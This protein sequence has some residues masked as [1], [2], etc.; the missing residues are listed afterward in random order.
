MISELSF[1]QAALKLRITVSMVW[2]GNYIT[3]KT[4][5]FSNEGTS[6]SG[7]GDEDLDKWAPPKDTSI[8]G[9]IPVS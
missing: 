9:I 1:H 5:S 3:A 2:S 4:L 7:G 8:L 6:V